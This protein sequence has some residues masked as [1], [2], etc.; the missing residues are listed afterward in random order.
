V[1][2]CGGTDAIAAL[3]KAAL[4]NPDRRD[5]ELIVRSL[6]TMDENGQKA[7]KDLSNNAVL[8]DWIAQYQGRGRFFEIE[9]TGFPPIQRNAKLD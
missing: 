8:K 4:Q 9:N 3:K 6:E 1:G 2:L 7:L 5:L